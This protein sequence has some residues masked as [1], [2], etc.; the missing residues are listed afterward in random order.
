M[1]CRTTCGAAVV[2][3]RQGRE[4][5]RDARAVDAIAS[6][7]KRSADENV[8]FDLVHVDDAGPKELAQ[9]APSWRT[10]RRARNNR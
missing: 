7:H 1:V 8:I 4:Q 5:G 3:A 2:S 10:W 6:T 9:A